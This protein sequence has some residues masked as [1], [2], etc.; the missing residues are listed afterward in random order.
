[1]FQS[2]STSE[3][4]YFPGVEGDDQVW[5][6]LHIHERIAHR[7]NLNVAVADDRVPAY[8]RG[9]T[10]LPRMERVRRSSALMQHDP[11]TLYVALDKSGRSKGTLFI[12]DGESFA[13]REG[14]MLYMQFDYAEGK[15]TSTQLVQPGYETRSWL[16]KVVIVG[17]SSD[18]GAAKLVTPGGGAPQDL[19][20]SF[21][22]SKG[23][24][25]VRKPGVNMAEKWQIEF[26]K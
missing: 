2:G 7:G 15:L 23:V 8:Q 14:K 17:L 1:M 3:T 26:G 25:T 16:E 6:D 10:I 19:Q 13:Y 22:A 5:Y 21:D 24:L 11:Y 20:T 12:D 9:G 4:V 18:P